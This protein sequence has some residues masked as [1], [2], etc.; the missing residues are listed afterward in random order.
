MNVSK[1]GEGI[2]HLVVDGALAHF[3]AFDMG[4]G[5]AQRESSGGGRQHFVAVGDQEQ[6]IGPPGR[7]CIG[8][9]E[10]GE[11]DGLG[12]AGVSV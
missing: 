10:N 2:A 8:E 1:F 3:T 9:S 11:A 6:Q 4:D 7:E 12:H 5:N